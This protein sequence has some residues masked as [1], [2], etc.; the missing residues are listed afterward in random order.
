MSRRRVIHVAPDDDDDFGAPAGGLADSLLGNLGGASFLGGDSFA[1]CS[2]ING[3]SEIYTGRSPPAAGAAESRVLPLTQKIKHTLIEVQGTTFVT[4]DSI[5]LGNVTDVTQLEEIY[6]ELSAVRE[7]LGGYLTANGS[8]AAKKPTGGAAA[9]LK[10]Q[11]NQGKS[12]SPPPA[13]PVAVVPALSDARLEFSQLSQSASQTPAAGAPAKSAKAR[14]KSSCAHTAEQLEAMTVPEL[15]SLLKK[16]KLLVSGTK[17]VLVERLLAAQGG[18]Q[19]GFESAPPQHQ[20]SES[21]VRPS[22][23]TTAGRTSFSCKSVDL[24]AVPPSPIARCSMLS[25]VSGQSDDQLLLTPAPGQQQHTAHRHSSG[26]TQKSHG[27]TFVMDSD[28]ETPSLAQRQPRL[29]AEL[30]DSEPRESARLSNLQGAR[31]SAGMFSTTTYDEEDE[32]DRE[33]EED[34]EEDGFTNQTWDDEDEED[35]AEQAAAAAARLSELSREASQ[36]QRQSI[37]GRIL[38]TLSR[39]SSTRGS[40]Q[41]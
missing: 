20:A 18:P 23:A 36:P 12:Q 32:E 26:P 21:A 9:K 33:V 38:S 11:Q 6:K 35:P 37:L 4:E 14:S 5:A 40:Q 8:K 7:A 16:K 39:T 19:L 2:D 34:D 30:E 28:D 24:S 25:R 29:V 17:A 1:A 27:K 41:Q 22:F 10:R 31:P 13:A 15:K 3:E